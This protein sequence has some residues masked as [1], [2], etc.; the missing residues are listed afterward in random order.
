MPAHNEAGG[1]AD[2]LRALLPQL[3]S[4]I[5]LVIVA[6]NCTDGTANIAREVV[7]HHS[8]VQVIER[9]D[10]E[11]RGKGYALDFGLRH[12]EKSPPEVILILDSDCE[13]SAGAIARLAS[14]CVTRN[15]PVQALYL[16][17]APLGASVKTKLAEFAWL[18]KNHV[19]ALGYSRL[20]LPCQ[21]MGTGMAFTWAKLAPPN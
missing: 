5:Y 11:R 12:I 15:R 10:A 18:V 7:A 14:L 16:M 3:G 21:L 6:D 19:R 4:N 8:G 1:I 13:L 17:Y 9:F 20:G 2:V